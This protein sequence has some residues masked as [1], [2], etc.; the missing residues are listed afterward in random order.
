MFVAN[1]R[2]N[3]FCDK[4]TNLSTLIKVL[5]ALDVTGLCVGDVKIWTWGGRQVRSLEAMKSR[6]D[7]T[8]K[9]MFLYN[10]I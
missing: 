8:S 10:K 6:D 2:R 9:I 1:W 7:G 5:S 4:Y 3:L